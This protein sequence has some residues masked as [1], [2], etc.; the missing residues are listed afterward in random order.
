MRLANKLLIF[1][2]LL[3]TTGEC[4]ELV[5]FLACDTE[6]KNIETSVYKDLSNMR[7]EALRISHYTGLP[8]KEISLI[9][10]ELTPPAVL[11]ALKFLDVEHDDVVLFYFSGHGF[12]TPS[13][14]D[15][16]WPN[17]FFSQTWEGIDYGKVIDILSDKYPRLLITV[18][19]CC[20]NIMEEHVAPP[21][22]IGKVDRTRKEIKEQA[23]RELFMETEGRVLVAS[24]Q[25]GEFSWSV[26][27]G[28]LFTS[29][30]LESLKKE[31][32]KGCSNWKTILDRSSRKVKFY[33]N[34]YYQVE[35]KPAM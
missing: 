18:A 30:F 14:E 15:D 35:I 11:N 2:L 13:K 28:A 23:Y 19:D 5:L 20:N 1:I 16:P 8:I 22:F 26:S 32:E 33:Q 6:A 7:D 25:I 34:P 29:A 17:L 3:C 4:G 27:K 31:S 9:G 12:R 21:I 10:H 24:S